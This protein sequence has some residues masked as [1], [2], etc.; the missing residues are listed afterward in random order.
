M[1]FLFLVR[2]KSGLVPGKGGLG[3]HTPVRIMY[4][5]GCL[6]RPDNFVCGGARGVLTVA[7]LHVV[8][9]SKC[10]VVL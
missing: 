1:Y 6:T 4:I 5:V 8:C 7:A 3:K 10:R 2:E 9:I